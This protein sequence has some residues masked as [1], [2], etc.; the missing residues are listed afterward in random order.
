MDINKNIF[1]N[2][3]GST[4]V[5]VLSVMT[6]LLAGVFSFSKMFSN[7]VKNNKN[8]NNKYISRYASESGIEKVYF[9]KNNP[10]TNYGFERIISD[11]VSKTNVLSNNASYT[12]KSNIRKTIKIASLD[13]GKTYEIT[14]NKT[15][16]FNNVKSVNV[17]WED[18]VTSEKLDFQFKKTKPTEEIIIPFGS[19]DLTMNPVNRNLNFGM[20]LGTEYV[21][22]IKTPE[23]GI[24]IHNIAIT[25]YNALNG[26]AGSG[27]PVILESIQ[28]VEAA[29][30]FLNNEQINEMTNTYIKD[31]ESLMSP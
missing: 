31:Q 21:L 10:V 20:P 7:S 27:T 22:T 3:E 8:L 19:L 2:K 12:L 13:L 30:K 16:D 26:T 29:G 14:F 9:Y 17:S 5:I 25:F 24:K 4:L 23:D 1:N 6:I 28:G 15:N 11:D 18:L